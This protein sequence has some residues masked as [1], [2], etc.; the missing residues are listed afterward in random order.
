MHSA[1]WP[2]EQRALWP[3][4]PVAA[5]SWA[6]AHGFSSLDLLEISWHSNSDAD[7]LLVHLQWSLPRT[8]IPTCRPQLHWS[9]DCTLI[10]QNWWGGSQP[11]PTKGHYRTAICSSSQVQLCS[12]SSPFSPASK[13]TFYHTFMPPTQPLLPN[14]WMSLPLTTHLK[15]WHHQPGP[16][17]P[18]SPPSHPS[19]HAFQQTSREVPRMSSRSARAKSATC[20]KN[21]AGSG[22]PKNTMSGFTTPVQTGQQ[23]TLSAITSAWGSEG[24]NQGRW[25]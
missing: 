24:K 2:P 18:C 4:S 10:L 25:L 12:W 11:S 22:S 13:L 3:F 8:R 7:Q 23:G 17:P 21:L 16:T 1:H 5:Y 6:P 19:S 15:R 14:P 20:S 9:S